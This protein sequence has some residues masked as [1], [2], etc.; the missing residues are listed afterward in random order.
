VI[1]EESAVSSILLPKGGAWR[2]G[3]LAEAYRL[4]QD[5]A[6]VP[7]A[8]QSPVY[9]AVVGHLDDAKAVANR[10]IPYR[11]RPGRPIDW[12][13]GTSVESAWESLHLAQEGLVMLQGEA[14]LE[15]QSSHFK[16]L[17]TRVYAPDQAEAVANALDARPLDPFVAKQVLIAYHASSDA[18][19]QAARNLRNLYFTLSFLIGSA[20]IAL[21]ATGVT[22]GAVIGLG[23]LGGAISVVFALQSGSANSPY[24]V[25]LAQAL[26]KIASGSATGL[27][28]V[29]LLAYGDTTLTPDSLKAKVYAVAFGFSQQAFTQLADKRAGVVNS[30]TQSRSAKSPKAT[31]N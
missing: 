6:E 16:A 10:Q 7:N 22:S 30:A 12:W 5:L 3:A 27:M 17:A 1:Q 20:A 13:N 19:H 11:A 2:I 25:L 15:D 4:E 31:S 8:D 21:A 26:L 28:A 24:N 9:G 29:I 14:T 18:S 23:A